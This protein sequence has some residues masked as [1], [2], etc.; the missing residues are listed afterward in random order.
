[1]I[2]RPLLGAIAVSP[3]LVVEQEHLDEIASGLRAG[4]DSLG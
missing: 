2:V 1:V 3:P 4:L